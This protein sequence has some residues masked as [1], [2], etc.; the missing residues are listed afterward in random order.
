[1]GLRQAYTPSGREIQYWRCAVGV[2]CKEREQ[3]A[4]NVRAVPLFHSLEH[5]P[6]ADCSAQGGLVAHA[7]FGRNEEPLGQEH[8]HAATGANGQ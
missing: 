5:I 2:D 1:M 7:T 6:N 3:I 8:L 4:L